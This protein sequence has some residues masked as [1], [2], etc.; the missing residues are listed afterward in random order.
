MP[1]PL[2]FPAS[3]PD[4]LLGEDWFGE[5][6]V[7]DT[8]EDLATALAA[9]GRGEMVWPVDALD[10][11]GVSVP[12]LAE[13]TGTTTGYPVAWPPA[14]AVTPSQAPDEFQVATM[15]SSHAGPP[16]GWAL[17]APNYIGRPHRLGGAAASERAGW[18]IRQSVQMLRM[19]E[20]TLYRL[21]EE[22]AELTWQLAALAYREPDA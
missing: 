22:A 18:S 10:L 1:P 14:G 15:P 4:E 21:R 12:S 17:H 20:N 16:T 8:G 13:S 3:A 19:T 2:E 7:F 11:S 6:S 9:L 5:G